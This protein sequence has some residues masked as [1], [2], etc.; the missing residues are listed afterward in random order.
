MI[1][2]NSNKSLKVVDLRGKFV[3]VEWLVSILNF[4]SLSMH[5]IHLVVTKQ[6]FTLNVL[7]Q[8]YCYGYLP[9]KDLSPWL[10]R[11]GDHS[12]HFRR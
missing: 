7:S 1:F 8:I 6:V 9:F 5:D 10:G 3:I 11:L 12:P 2:K 4:G